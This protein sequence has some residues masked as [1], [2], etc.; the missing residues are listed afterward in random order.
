MSKIKEKAEKIFRKLKNF[1]DTYSDKIKFT[2][3]AFIIALFAMFPYLNDIVP[4]THDFGYHL[5]R[6]NEIA[7]G[8]NIRKFPVLIH[9]GL[10][11][12]LGYGNGFFYP[13]LYIFRLY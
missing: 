12:N 8:L 13:Q 3:V 10:I 2:I 9:A 6:I 4:F 1:W 5:N 11:E 7:N